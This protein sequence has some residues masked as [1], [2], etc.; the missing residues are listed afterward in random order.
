MKD[1]KI[2]L[3]APPELAAE[4]AEY[5]PVSLMAYEVARGLRLN[6]S[7]TVPSPRGERL[8]E[9]SCRR[10]TG[11]GPQAA[12]AESIL[13]QCLIYGFSGAVLDLPRPTPAL[14][15]LAEL[16]SDR[17]RP[18]GL[19][20][21]LP[22]GYGGIPGNPTILVSAQ[23]YCAPYIDRLRALAGRFGAGRL[24][25]RL[26]TRPADFLLPARR[27]L[28]SRLPS[29]VPGGVQPDRVFYSECHEAN[30]TSFLDRGR[31]RLVMWDDA[32]SVKRKLEIAENIGIHTAFLD[33]EENRSIIRNLI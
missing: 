4:A 27:S 14:M 3:S 26:D 15:A 32:N 13:R 5:A 18:R 29:P 17:F 20:L 12:L 22:E 11:F 23:S 16:M 24:A 19:S 33:F 6:R 30:Y 28:P 7:P 2:Y 8:M 10:L 9:V 25:L 1:F 31:V 21:Y